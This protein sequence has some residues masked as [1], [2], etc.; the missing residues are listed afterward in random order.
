M[1]F[2]LVQFAS[3][4]LLALIP[5]SQAQWDA[6]RYAWYNGD[7]GS[8]FASAVPI[9]NGRLGAAIF[10]TVDEVVKLNENSIWSGPWQDRANRNS[11][12]ALSNIR[13]QLM[14]GDITSAGSAT[15]SNSEY[16]NAT[17]MKSILTRHSG[18][19]SHFTPPV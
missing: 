13:S 16:R 12:N 14:N 11:K 9:G 7:A 17:S 1:A 15:L 10:G 19:K 3:V 18:W 8:D 2:R 5:T 6:S 4:A